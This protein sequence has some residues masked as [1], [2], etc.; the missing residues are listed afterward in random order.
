MGKKREDKEELHGLEDALRL[1]ELE[2]GWIAAAVPDVSHTV[3]VKVATLHGRPEIVGMRLRPATF[4]SLFEDP[5]MKTSAVS[6]DLLW[7]F[8]RHREEKFIL[9][10]ETPVVTVS[11]LRRIPLGR[12]LSAILVWRGA[13]A[14]KL[15][16][17]RASLKWKRQLTDEH[18]IWV[19][20]LYQGAVMFGKAPLNVIGQRGKVPRSTAAYWVRKARERGFLGYPSAPGKAG[21]AASESP[22]QSVPRQKGGRPLSARAEEAARR[23]K[24]KKR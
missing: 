5:S 23:A 22:W 11:L 24:Q 6:A 8:Q 4:G 17:S 2:D 9:Q 12:I 3:D 14:D 18:L 16:E 20:E 7:K 13:D 10:A 15:L 21:F 19:A 1:Q